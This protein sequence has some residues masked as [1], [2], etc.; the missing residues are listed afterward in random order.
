MIHEDFNKS[1]IA[2]RYYAKLGESL[3]KQ[4]AL[5][6]WRMLRNPDLRLLRQVIREVSREAISKIALL[7]QHQPRGKR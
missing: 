7:P 3:S 6:R 4:E 5:N 2:R 1:A